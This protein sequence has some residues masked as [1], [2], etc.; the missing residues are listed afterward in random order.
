MEVSEMTKVD[1]EGSG[2]EAADEDGAASRESRGDTDSSD[3]DPPSSDRSEN[4]T[5]RR[6][7]STSY[8]WRLNARPRTELGEDAQRV[9]EL[10]RPMRDYVALGFER[11]LDESINDEMAEEIMESV[12]RRLSRRLGI[13]LPRS[14]QTASPESRLTYLI[15]RVHATLEGGRLMDDTDN[16]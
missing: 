3:D 5:P 4:A 2:A 12:V 9:G 7:R 13:M 8:R 11:R 1:S 6:I 10:I 15:L 14:L 16:L